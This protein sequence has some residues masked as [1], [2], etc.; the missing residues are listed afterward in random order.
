M[1]ESAQ[2]VRCKKCDGLNPRDAKFCNNC[3]ASLLI[4]FQKEKDDLEV[5]FLSRYKFGVVIFL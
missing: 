2:V 4:P 1:E 3:G 5:S